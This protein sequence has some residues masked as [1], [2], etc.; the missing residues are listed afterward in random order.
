MGTGIS[1]NQIFKM[2][3]GVA[4]PGR[5][6]ANLYVLTS[7]FHLLF[8]FSPRSLLVLNV[9]SRRGLYQHWSRWRPQDGPISQD[10]TTIDVHGA[11]L[12][13]GHRRPGELWLVV[14]RLSPIVHLLK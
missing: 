1:T 4:N 9:E 12:G 3:A 10:S 8:P 2:I 14:H 5:P 13:N 7:S 11:N 6:V